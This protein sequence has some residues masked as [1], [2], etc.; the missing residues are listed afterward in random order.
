VNLPRRFADRHPH[1][2]SGGERQ[3]VAIARALSSSPEVVVLDEPVTSLD[4]SV[5]GSIINLLLDRAEGVTY[6]I[7]SHD[8][9]IIHHLAASLYVMFKGL[10]VEQGPTA[11]I[12]ANPLH[13]YTQVLVASIS[14]PLYQPPIDSDDAAPTSACPYLPRCPHAMDVCHELPQLTGDEHAVRCR[15]YEGQTAARVAVRAHTPVTDDAATSAAPPADEVGSGS[16]APP[17]P[18]QELR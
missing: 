1:E 8:L 5:R 10:V 6:V 12:L 3:R 4:V 2:L 16:V 9:T 11:E 13:P 15:L 17:A 18:V 14:N 7:V